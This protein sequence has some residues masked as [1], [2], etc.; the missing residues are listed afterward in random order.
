MRDESDTESV[1]ELTIVLAK[2][3]V[4]GRA[5]TRLCPPCTPENAARLAQASLQDTLAA[6][7]AWGGRRVLALDPCGTEFSI[8]G[9]DTIGQPDGGLDVRLDGVFA[10]V[11]Q[12]N[13]NA[14]VPAP[15][16][17]L[18]GM[19]TPQITATDLS[20]AF[21]ILRDTDA[22]IG[23]ASDGG[24]WGIGF[25]AMPEN[26]FIGVPMSTDATFDAQVARL[27]ELGLRVTILNELDDIDTFDDAIQVGAAAPNT[28]VGQLVREPNWWTRSTS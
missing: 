17:F 9:W 22:V 16:V 24:Y 4:P 7:E 28:R 18:V 8:E 6:V 20:E 2:A 21:N 13:S 26:A 5:K 1:R 3:P 15:A 11:Y 12:R 19:D 25:T 27:H 23:P 10:D 14:G